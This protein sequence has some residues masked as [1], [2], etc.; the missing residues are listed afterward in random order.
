VSPEKQQ[1]ALGILQKKRNEI[2][3]KN[4]KARVKSAYRAQGIPEEVADLDE[5]AQKEYFKQR[6]EA[7]KRTAKGKAYEQEGLPDY[8]ADLD[9]LTQRTMIK[10]KEEQDLFSRLLPSSASQPSEMPQQ[11]IPGQQMEQQG[12]QSPL[13]MDSMLDQVSPAATQQSGL[14]SIPDDQLVIMSGKSGPIG[15]IAKS[16]QLRRQEERKLSQKE[17][18]EEKQEIRE[19]KK[20]TLPLRMEIA[21]RGNAAR[22]GIQNKSKLIEI[23]NTG[24]VNDPTFSIVA[25]ALPLNLGKRLL[26]PETVEY[27][28]GLVDEFTDLRNIF[29]GQT[30]IKEIDLLEQ[31]I[32]DLYLTD[33]QKKTILK[34]RI[35]ALQADII[36][37]E[38]AAEVEQK[39][40][41]LGALQFSRKVE[42]IARPKLEKVFN[43]I[44]EEQRF[45]INQ[46]EKRKEISLD[47]KNPDDFAIL[48]QILKEAGGNKEEARKLAKK[49]GYKF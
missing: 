39:F 4:E 13:N 10:G 6:S 36:R 30:R 9:P 29:Q 18:S 48:K 21:N 7:A 14:R 16:E 12:M 5:Q 17:K 38:A 20:E 49:R 32:A 8:Y 34:S 31:K 15:Q 11:A 42:E 37:E 23:I 24:N 40:P 26:S 27:K 2:V 45:I 47:P 35:N 19:N 41:N 46:A 44:L 25:E 1:A 3:A 22:K 43:Q 33:E 28:A